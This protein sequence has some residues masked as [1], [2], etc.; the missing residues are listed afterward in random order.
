MGIKYKKNPAPA[1]CG[2]PSRLVVKRERSGAKLPAIPRVSGPVDVVKAVRALIADRAYEVFLVLYLN[3]KNCVFAY[4][5]LTEDSVAAVS[6]NSASLVRN[7]LLSGAVG[8]ITAH[9]HPSG[10]LDPSDEDRALWRQLREQC[11]LMGIL[12]LDNA[13]VTEDGYYFESQD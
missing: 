2:K 4:E 9:Q 1:S 10:S 8:I 3:T 5:E 13:I 12:L 7:A 11:K 6:V